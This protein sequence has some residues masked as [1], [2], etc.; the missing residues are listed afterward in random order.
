[1]ESIS[2]SSGCVATVATTRGG[3]RESRHVLSVV[4]HTDG[5]ASDGQT[6]MLRASNKDGSQPVTLHLHPTT[7]RLAATAL[8][9][10]ADRGEPH[11]A[12]G[13]LAMVSV[14]RICAMTGPVA[15]EKDR[16]SFA[17]TV[18]DKRVDVEVTRRLGADWHPRIR[19]T[20]DGGTAYSGRPTRGDRDAWETLMDL[21]LNAQAAQKEQANRFALEALQDQE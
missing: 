17:Y 9:D 20:V 16:L 2:H 10:A 21:L 8:L 18:G 12:E 5:R 1:M 15:V 7:A 19:V 3:K 6:V 14:V 13:V 11:Q 4:H